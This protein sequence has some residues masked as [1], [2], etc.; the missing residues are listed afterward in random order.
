MGEALGDL[1]TLALDVGV[2]VPNIV[3]E[4]WDVEDA[5]FDTKEETE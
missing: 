2:F 5:V 3:F 4:G 1:E